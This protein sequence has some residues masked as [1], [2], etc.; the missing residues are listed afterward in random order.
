MTSGEREKRVR[1]YFAKRPKQ[2]VKDYVKGAIGLILIIIGAHIAFLLVI[3]ILVLLWGGVGVAR[4]MS[5]V[6]KTRPKATDAEMDAW[7]DAALIPTAEKGVT[8]LNVHP[9]EV[10]GSMEDSRLIFVGY[11]NIPNVKKA[12]GDDKKLRYSHYEI[13]VVYLSN[14]RLPVYQVNYDM[15]NNAN[16]LENTKEYNLAQVD[17]IET[18]NDRITILSNEGD[19]AKNANQGGQPSTGAIGHVT[20]AQLLSLMVSGNRAV[21]LIT[22]VT[23][24]ESVRIE[25]V[26]EPS[27]IDAM[28]SRLREHLRVRHQGA[29]QATTGGPGNAGFGGL[30]APA[31]LGLDLPPQAAAFQPNALGQGPGFATPESDPSR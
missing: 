24:A 14:W 7:L 9:T 11:P 5:R 18:S 27:K 16:V 21:T 4:Y 31:G 12:F 28:I 26:D 13:L 29:Y 20:T 6:S 1:N 19:N 25:N 2:P 22:G 23:G 3:G 10:T 30:G 15:E 8:R 17:G